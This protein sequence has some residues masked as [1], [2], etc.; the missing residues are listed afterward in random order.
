MEANDDFYIFLTRAFLIDP[1]PNG[2]AGI[3]KTS[4]KEE[5]TLMRESAQERM[6]FLTSVQEEIDLIKESRDRQRE[7]KVKIAFGALLREEEQ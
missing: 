2:C 5:K 4:D 3:T 1:A 6:L 7:R